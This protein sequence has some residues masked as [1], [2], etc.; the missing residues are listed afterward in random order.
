MFTPNYN[1]SIKQTILLYKRLIKSHNQI[2]HGTDKSVQELITFNI[3]KQELI[4][5]AVTGT[6]KR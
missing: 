2:L 5:I 4:I 1:Q 3:T 6:G